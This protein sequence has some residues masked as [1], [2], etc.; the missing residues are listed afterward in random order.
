MATIIRNPQIGEKPRRVLSGSLSSQTPQQDDLSSTVKANSK[1]QTTSRERSPSSSSPISQRKQAEKDTNIM[2]S[3]TLTEA[4]RLAN[5]R[6][7]EAERRL[8]EYK[9]EI[10]SHRDTAYEDGY[11]VGRDE[12]V[13][14]GLEEYLGKIEVLKEITVKLKSRIESVMDLSLIHI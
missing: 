9:A 7:E 13:D 11:T 6:A 3:N 5:A 1:E 8:A 10:D 2:E 14:K 4:L 12:G